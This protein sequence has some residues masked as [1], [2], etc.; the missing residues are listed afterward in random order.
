MSLMDSSTLAKESH[1]S[2][3][4]LWE[5]RL[6]S[7]A[8]AKSNTAAIHEA[9]HETIREILQQSD[10]DLKST[11]R[12]SFASTESHVV[13][14]VAFEIWERALVSQSVHA[15][16][17]LARTW[18]DVARDFYER[19]GA[20]GSDYKKRLHAFRSK[21]VARGEEDLV[22]LPSDTKTFFA[23]LRTALGPMLI[24]K[25]LILFFGINY[26]QYPGEGYGWGLVVTISSSLAMLGWFVWS[27]SGKPESN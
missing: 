13:L 12:F 24:A 20:E 11:S 26:S 5:K 3:L 10:Q 16:T 4:A 22:P 23:F 19:A 1:R 7:A 2:L 15:P 17:D 8:R 14:E 21:A 27:Q 25:S 6:G 18:N 9:V